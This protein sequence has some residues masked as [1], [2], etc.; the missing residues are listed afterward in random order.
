MKT[1][2][3]TIRIIFLTL[4]LVSVSGL[5][6]TITLTAEVDRPVM[7]AGENQTGYLRVGLTG[8][9]VEILKERPEPI[10]NTLSGVHVPQGIRAG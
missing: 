5:A 4:L 10:T 9:P 3:Q 8:C 6:D 2:N 1:V 7:L